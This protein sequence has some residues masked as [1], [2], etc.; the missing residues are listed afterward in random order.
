[1]FFVERRL[2]RWE[3]SSKRK[4]GVHPPMSTKLFRVI[5]PVSDID[6]AESFYRFLL[7]SPGRR[8][9][10]GR[11]YFDC[12]EPFSP[13]MI[14]ML[15]GMPKKLIPIQNM[16]TL[17]WKSLKRSLLVHKRRV[18]RNSIRRS[19]RDLGE[20]GAFMRVIPLETLSALWI[21]PPFLPGS[22]SSP[23][24]GCGPH[25]RAETRAESF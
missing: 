9:S 18:A 6:R 4:G 8:V 3:T 10:S 25:A 17:Q 21:A 14:L 7:Q 16:S 19:R 2:D 20:N 13:V 12:G 23:F 5:L 24:S 11:H 1:V 15:M 22:F